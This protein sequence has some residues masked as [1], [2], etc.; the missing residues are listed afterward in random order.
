MPNFQGSGFTMELPDDCKD[1]SAY[2]F[3][4]PENNGFAANL[5]VRFE[6]A[7]D[8]SDLKA[9]VNTSLKILK[10]NVIDFVMIKQVAGKRGSNSGVMSN[11]EW[12][13]GETR[14]RIKQYCIMTTGDEPRIYTLTASDLAINADHST[15]VFNR[16]MKSFVPNQEQ[17]F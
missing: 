10:A 17:L 4:L 6:P 11:F 1:A 15:P 7:I 3:V 2:T 12:G 5:A 8:I 14:M 9:H 13:A 16:M